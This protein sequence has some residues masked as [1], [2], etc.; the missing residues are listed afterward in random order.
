MSGVEL[1]VH[2]SQI[3]VGVKW[4][5]N[6]SLPPGVAIGESN[7]GQRNVGIDDLPRHWIN[8]V[9]ANYIRHSVAD[10]GRVSG[11]IGRFGCRGSKIAGAFQGGGNAG[12]AQECA[13]CLAQSR[14]G[15]EEESLVLLDGAA[16]R[17]TE[18]V[19]MKGRA[20][21]LRAPVIGIENG[22]GTNS[23]SDPWTCWCRSW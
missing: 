10:E 1:I 12:A 2:L 4:G 21:K 22:L 15:E 17:G 7:V 19:A 16:N 6:I 11:G 18:L 14:V 3:L 13:G 9:R 8:S 23:K 5:G 20:G